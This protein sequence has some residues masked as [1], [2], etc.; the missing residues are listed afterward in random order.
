VPCDQ[1]SFPAIAGGGNGNTSFSY[2]TMDST[3]T[4]V[5][6]GGYSLDSAL[7]SS[8]TPSILMKL[9]HSTGLF[10][11]GYEIVE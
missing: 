4:F 11:W 9:I 8:A 6:I 2:A 10:E 5:L 3:L 1:L 7:V